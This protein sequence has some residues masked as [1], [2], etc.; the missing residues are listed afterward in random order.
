MALVN[1]VTSSMLSALWPSWAR[2]GYATSDLTTY[3][4]AAFA[5]VQNLLREQGVDPDTVVEDD[6]S[7]FNRVIGFKAL[8]LL[9][10]DL[11]TGAGGSADERFAEVQADYEERFNE[12]WPNISYRLM[13]DG[14]EDNAT[15]VDAGPLTRLGRA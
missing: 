13:E 3:S 8:E 7:H 11:Q 4:A 14:N 12:A 1:N 2:Y 15:T 6:S 5:Y 9:H 10:Q